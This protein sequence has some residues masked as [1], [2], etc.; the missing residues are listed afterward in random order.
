VIVDEH[1][2]SIAEGFH[3]QFGGPHAEIDALNA[4]GPRAA[5]Q[6]LFVTLEPC[7]HQGKTGPCTEA[8]IRSGIRKV[9]VATQDPAPHVAGGGI[10]A[11]N[12]AGIE[13]EVGLL[14]DEA[15]ARDSTSRI[16]T[17]ATHLGIVTVR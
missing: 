5:G 7:C 8:V 11:L 3:K 12:A 2:R 1:L 14:A 17:N 4:A 15:R 13:V 10:A 16:F 6:V 9:V